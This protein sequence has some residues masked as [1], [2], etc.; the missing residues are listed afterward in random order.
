M[1]ISLKKNFIELYHLRKYANKG[2]LDW[3]ISK[4]Q[5]KFKLD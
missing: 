3:V 1:K 2:I 5:C 4:N